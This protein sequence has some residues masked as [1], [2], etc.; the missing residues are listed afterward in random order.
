MGDLSADCRAAVQESI[1]RKLWLEEPTALIETD[2]LPDWADIP[3]PTA[4]ASALPAL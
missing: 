2:E 4:T 3:A 1:Q